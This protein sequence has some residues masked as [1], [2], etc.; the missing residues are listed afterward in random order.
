MVFEKFNYRTLNYFEIIVVVARETHHAKNVGPAS[1]K[2]HTHT[3]PHTG[4]NMQV[5]PKL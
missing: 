3:K 1:L 5:Y 4:F 2:I